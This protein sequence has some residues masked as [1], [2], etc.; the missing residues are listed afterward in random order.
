M[1]ARAR[2]PD[3][4]R[5]NDAVHMSRIKRDDTKREISLRSALWRRGLRF[6]KHRR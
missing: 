2:V 4:P 5:R 6:R 1:R 3:D